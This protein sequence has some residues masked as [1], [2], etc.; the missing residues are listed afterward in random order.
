[1]VSGRDHG[2]SWGDGWLGQ[3]TQ[4]LWYLGC[5][6]VGSSRRQVVWV[7]AEVR[8]EVGSGKLLV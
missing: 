5:I 8:A 4:G 6:Q 1:M 3:D 7:W 2:R